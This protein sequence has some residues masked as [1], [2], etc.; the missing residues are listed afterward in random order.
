MRARSI[1]VAFALLFATGC[2]L[3]DASINRPTGLVGRWVQLRDDGSW[4]DTVAYLADGRL[5]GSRGVAIPDSADWS[6]VTFRGS[7]G[8]CAE[9]VTRT[10]EPFRLVGDTLVVGEVGK[11]RFF[12]RVP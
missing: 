12:R 3:S 9:P 1:G 7:D 6:V 4:G 8:L 11:Y 10:C 2:A 5:R